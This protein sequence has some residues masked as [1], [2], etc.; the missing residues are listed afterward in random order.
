VGQLR[1]MRILDQASASEKDAG[2]SLAGPEVPALDGGCR[3]MSRQVGGGAAR[4]CR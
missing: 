3:V 2:G 4:W 1:S